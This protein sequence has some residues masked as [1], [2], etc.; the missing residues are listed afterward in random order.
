MSIYNLEKLFHPVSVAVIGASEKDG[1][2]GTAVMR[3]LVMSGFTG[4]VYPVNPGHRKMWDRKCYQS[5]AELPQPVDLAVIVTPIRTVPE[6]VKQ[7]R[8]TGCGGAVV[9]SAGGKEIGAAGAQIEG[10]IR[11]AAIDDRFR[12]IGPN[13]L[14]IMSVK[15]GL[16]ASFANRMPQQGRM[17]FISQ[18]GAI[19]TSILDFSIKEHIGFSYFVSLGS[20]LDVDFGDVIDYLGADPDVSSIVMYIENLTHVRNFMSAARAV[21]RVKPIIALKSGRTRAGALAA[22]SHTGALASED[23]VYDVA[24]KRAGIIRVRTFQELFDCAELLAKQPQIQGPG[25]AIVTN[26]GGPGVMAADALTD[27]GVEPVKLKPET[28]QRLD[29]LLPAHWSRSNPVDIL[30]DASPE[31]FRQVVEVLAGAREV[32]GLLIMFAPQAMSHPTEV[33]SALIEVLRGR[34]LPVFTAWMGGA[35]VEAGRDLF[36]R[37]GISTFD[38]PERAVRAFMD[39]YHY[40]KNIEMLQQIPPA[41][42]NLLAF[43]RDAA[44][45]LIE[46]GLQLPTGILNE[47]DAKTLLSAYGI[48]VNR[49]VSAANAEEAVA[50]AEGMGYP[51]VMKIFSPEITHKTDA[52]G[53][54][55]NID[56]ADRIR[57]AFQQI[58]DNCRA[59]DSQAVINGVTLQKMIPSPEYELIAGVKK[60]KDFGP[61]LLFGMGGIFTEIFKDK[62]L[63]LPPLN[64]LLARRMMEETKVYGILKGYRSRPAADLTRLEEM[65]IRLS[66]LVCDFPEIEAVDINPLFIVNQAPIALDARV[67]VAPSEIK[68]PFHLVISPYPNRYEQRISHNDVGDLLIRPIRPEDAPLVV[69]LF[70][71]LSPQSIYFRFFSPLKT[72][73]PHMLA[74]FTQIDYDREIALVAVIQ[75]NERDRLLGVARV[76]PEHNRKQA[77]FAVLVADEWHGKGIGAALMKRC[78]EVSRPYR[79][80][81]IKGIVMADNTKMLALGKKLGFA[82][83][84]VPGSDTYELV[85]ECDRQEDCLPETG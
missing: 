35:E 38:T 78:L 19:C 8:E 43:D 51:V 5:V 72:L 37:A 63:A 52:G 1:S 61:V 4:Q 40:S 45:S 2:I 15:A 41:L 82:V 3:N 67:I 69:E 16:N 80:E 68:A 57:S 47:I 27:Y 29:A 53:V 85:L 64:R 54:I 11:S 71:T 83:R 36:N 56:S 7:C 65:M 55:L 32:N 66:Q 13:C 46:K 84:R 59:Y 25:L 79:F 74:R 18:S 70:N 50:R 9:I 44:Q 22:A 24:L 60:D 17:A 49:T 42:P 39:L 31:K 12:I 30:G 34:Q 73:P 10:A 28:L 26:A 62:A 76:I 75:E 77:E 14:G 48:S 58:M 23:A 33:A 21:S 20:M 6:I 81:K